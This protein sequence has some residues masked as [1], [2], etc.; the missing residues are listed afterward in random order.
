VLAADRTEAADEAKRLACLGRERAMTSGEGAAAPRELGGALPGWMQSMT[1]AFAARARRQWL[2]G[3]EGGGGGAERS[4]ES[5]G[6][7]LY[8]LFINSDPEARSCCGES[9]R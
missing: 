9:G 2:I 5:N 8:P 4:C 7:Q 3:L 1:A 6:G